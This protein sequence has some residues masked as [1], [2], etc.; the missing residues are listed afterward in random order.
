[1][2]APGDLAPVQP[3]S[4]P[5][6]SATPRLTGLTAAEA[7]ARLR[8]VG[9]NDPAPAQ[10]TSAVRDFLKLFLN[11][12]VLILLIAAV[13]SAVL[14]DAPS[15]AIIIVIVLL[16][17]VLDF[18]QTHRSQRAV[19][20]LQARVAPTATV[21][22][23]GKWQE[24]RRTDIVPGDV[25]RLSAGD[26]VAAD[27]RL[28]EARDLYVQQGALTGE[29]LPVEKRAQG[30]SISTSPALT[31]TTLLIVAAG[32]LLPISPLATLLGFAPLPGAYWGYLVG[33]TLVYLGMVE[34]AKRWLL[35]RVASSGMGGK[36][37]AG[38]PA[39]T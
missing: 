29:S 39:P 4:T 27:A 36:R 31:A 32:A 20:E 3:P 23:D 7:A 33:A 38:A 17:N 37:G 35:K 15:A 18:T 13:S 6:E 8:E 9:S 28:L 19:A 5:T 26:L 14:G 16:S 10:R 22:R 34:V 21:L 2:S 11:P 30:T 12:L 1:M 25:I 24:V